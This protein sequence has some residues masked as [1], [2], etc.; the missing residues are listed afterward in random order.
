MSVSKDVHIIDYKTFYIND[1]EYPVIYIYC[2]KLCARRVLVYSYG[3]VTRRLQD[4]V[5]L[6]EQSSCN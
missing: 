6:L 3:H 5:G 1:Y 4:G 2:D